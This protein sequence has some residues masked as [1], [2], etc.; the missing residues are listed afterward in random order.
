[1]CSRFL[2]PLL[3]LMFCYSLHTFSQ[4]PASWNLYLRINRLFGYPVN[5]LDLAL[6]LILTAG[7]ALAV[8]RSGNEFG[9]LV[10]GA[11]K[12]LR[13]SLEAIFGV[14]PRNTEI[15]GHFSMLWFL[16]L[17]PRG[18]RA[19]LLLLAAGVLGLTSVV[20]T[21]CHFHTPLAVSVMRVSLGLLISLA[22]FLISYF[23]CL[24]AFRL[25]N[26]SSRRLLD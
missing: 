2:P 8:L 4:S 15:I 25:I 16:V 6:L 26:L 24:A 17:Y 12:G 9:F 1:M 20:N 3:A 23:V 13:G 22:L 10:T 7:L 14:R 19:S 5:Y 18:H 11:E 21:F